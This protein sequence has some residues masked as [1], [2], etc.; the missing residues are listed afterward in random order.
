MSITKIKKKSLFKMDEEE[1]QN[2]I[3]NTYGCLICKKALSYKVMKSIF[4][5]E[6]NLKHSKQIRAL[7]EKSIVV[8]Y[9]ER[10]HKR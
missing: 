8:D 4:C 9:A 3:S 7:R 1:L 10:G 5:L 2:I 6:C